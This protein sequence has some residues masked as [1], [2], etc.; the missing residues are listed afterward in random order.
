MN[1]TERIYRFHTLIKNLRYPSLKRIM[2]ELECSES[3]VNRLKQNLTDYYGAP[4]KYDAEKNGYYYDESERKIDLPGFWL[5]PDEIYALFV[6]IQVIEK[7]EEIGISSII[8]P[9]SSKIEEI[10]AKSGHSPKN[11]KSL[12]KVMPLYSRIMKKGNF[13]KICSCLINNEIIEAEYF[14]RS[15][16]RKSTRKL[17]PQRLIHYKDN[18]Y[19]CAY[20]EKNKELRIFSVEKIKI[21]S[22]EPGAEK[23][24]GK[25]LDSFL[26]DGFGV[27]SGKAEN[28]AKLRFSEPNSNWV[29]DEIWHKNQ[30]KYFEGKDLVLEIPFSN[31]T[32]L[33]MEILRHG[34]GVVVESPEFLKELVI[35]KLK[36]NLKKYFGSVIF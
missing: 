22:T 4:L 18:W 10:I 24:S 25:E 20:C 35:E 5:S 1:K 30:K 19:L 7:S 15:C 29:K 26:E 34:D 28:I 21:L 31:P 32:E 23:F 6:C 36:K 12:I 14:T 16:K 3:T 33:V 2:E 17:H 11:L 9:L 27:F 8:S 13:S